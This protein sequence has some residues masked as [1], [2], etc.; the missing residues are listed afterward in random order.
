MQLSSFAHNFFKKAKV[1][2]VANPYAPGAGSQP[3]ELAGRSE[4]VSRT[5]TTLARVKAGRHAKSFMLVGL[6]GVGKTVLLNRI[7]QIAE[8]DGYT[9]TVIEAPEGKSLPELLIPCL[10]KILFQ[11]DTKEKVTVAVKRGMMVLKS[12]AKAVKVTV[13]EVE[14]GLDIDAEKGTGDSG[15]LDTDLADLFEVIGAAAKARNTAV[16]IIIDE[17]QYI[18]ETEFSAL[19]MAVHRI[20]QKQLP[21]IV[22]GAGLPQ[23]VGLAGKAKSYAERLFDYPEVDALNEKDAASALKEPAKR[24]GVDW[25]PQALKL[26][27]QLTRGYP[28]F[29]QEWGYHSWNAAKAGSGKITTKDVKSASEAARSN[30]DDSFFRVRFDR[31]SPR[32]KDYMFAMAA[33][34]PGAH[35][36]G[37][38]ATELG[39]PV[40]SVAPV[41]S[42]LIKKGMVYSPA[43]GDTAFTVPM[44][45]EY[46]IRIGR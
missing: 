6:R 42:S 5:E 12:F 11:L 28:Y 44:F 13:G 30:L 18:K 23:L 22:I 32:E 15:D 14:I 35:R 27:V 9:A 16:A 40:E 31:V 26:A 33:L 37:D 36:S 2:P 21:L 38:I 45:N 24:E 19:I 29:L 3:P 34:G 39:V 7:A 10:R 17:L 20:S 4:I 41:R 1:D 43:H 8:D 46:L 25:H